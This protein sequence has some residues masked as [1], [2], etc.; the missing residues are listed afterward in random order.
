MTAAEAASEAD[1]SCD[2]CGNK[3]R[4]VRA[5]RTHRGRM[6]KAATGSPIP[7]LD[8]GCET[9]DDC[10]NYT[11]VSKY[12]TEDIMYTLEEIFPSDV[13]TKLVSRVRTTEPKSADHLC[14]IRIQLAA[15]QYFVWPGMN[16]TQEDVIKDLTRI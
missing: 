13:E 5:L 3:F 2:I 16:R 1:H 15:P 4:S 8:G 6:H 12:A 11:F 10:V 7:Q 14:T 9:E